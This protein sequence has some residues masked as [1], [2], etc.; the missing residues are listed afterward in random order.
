VIPFYHNGHIAKKWKTSNIFIV[1]VSL[2]LLA[3]RET[4]RTRLAIGFQNTMS[5]IHDDLNY[6]P[7]SELAIK[8]CPFVVP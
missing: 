7:K 1:F 6:A 4:Y 3:T 8:A 2:H 5:Q